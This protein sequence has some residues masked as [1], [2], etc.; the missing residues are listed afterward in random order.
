MN[1]VSHSHFWPPLLSRAVKSLK[2]Q[3]AGKHSVW[4]QWKLD[5]QKLPLCTALGHESLSR[6][7]VS[8]KDLSV[9]P[10][11][12]FPHFENVDRSIPQPIEPIPHK[13]WL[14]WHRPQIASTHPNC[15][16]KTNKKGTKHMRSWRETSLGG[17]A[18]AAAKSSPEWRSWRETNEGRQ[19]KAEAPKS[20]PEWRS[21]RETN[22]GRQGGRSSQERARMEITQGDK[23]RETR[24][25]EQPKAGQNGDKWR[26]T[27]E[28][29][30][31][32]QGQARMEITKGDKWRETNEG[33]SSQEQARMEITNGGKWRETNEGRSSQ[34]QA[35]ME[36][37]QG[38]KGRETNEGRSGQ[39]QAR[40]EISFVSLHLSPF[41]ISILAC[42]WPLLPSFVSLHL[43]PWSPSWP[44]L[45]CPCLHVSPFICLPAW[46]P[47][48][49]ALG[50]ACLWE[51][52]TP[53][54]SSYLGKNVFRCFLYYLVKGS[55]VRSFRSCEQLG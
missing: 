20:R 26:E 44:A 37:T 48:W 11:G 55:L 47:F 7:I 31:G 38:D 34:E 9:L 19:M 52:R 28:G 29:G 24:R 12:H 35:K 46:S 41:V 27:N 45:G 2:L 5:H 33:R 36:I 8:S 23:W 25:Q 17:K 18:A 13:K 32:S 42:S 21:C 4:A 40:M 10:S 43:S 50:C 1:T 30:R 6:Q 14:H 53:I 51:V 39:E 16:K 3:A 49:P 54:A 15:K 22:E